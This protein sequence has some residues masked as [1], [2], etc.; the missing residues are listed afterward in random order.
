M[1]SVEERFWAKVQA[2]VSP[3]E[4]LIWIGARQ[5]LG[6]GSFR[7]EGKTLKAHRFSYEL[8]VGLIPEGLVID[9]LCRNR[10]CVRP[11][12]LEP[13]TQKVNVHRGEGVAA[14]K[15]RKTHCHKGHELAGKNL[16]VD[17]YGRHC[18]ACAIKRDADR[19]ALKRKR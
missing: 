7:V 5:S 3:D 18:R 9:H 14:V 12:H 8:N 15:A 2:P 4:C 1:K 6:Y 13:V 19:Y 10:A 16:R 11:D 17:S